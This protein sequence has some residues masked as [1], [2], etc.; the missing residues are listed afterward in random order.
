MRQALEREGGRKVEG[1]E[2]GKSIE[3]AKMK[4]IYFSNLKCNT[5]ETLLNYA[6][7]TW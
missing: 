5:G 2:L 7:I 6:N 4:P 1:L 3:W